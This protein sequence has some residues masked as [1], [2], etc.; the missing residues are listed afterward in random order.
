MLILQ[1]QKAIWL[2][3][4]IQFAGLIQFRVKVFIKKFQEQLNAARGVDSR[5]LR[6]QAPLQRWKDYIS[7][8]QPPPP[9]TT[10]DLLLLWQQN[11]VPWPTPSGLEKDISEENIRL[12]IKL[13]AV[14]Y[15]EQAGG[16]WKKAVKQNQY[17]WHPD[18]FRQIQ[19]RKLEKLTEDKKE[20]IM[21]RVT[22]VSQILNKLAKE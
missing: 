11:D 8:F 16:D 20:E 14:K 1:T 6:S 9:D 2:K 22:E 18:K 13:Y 19:A 5:N 12:F 7:A 15:S 4:L 21:S 3:I 10:L 17:F